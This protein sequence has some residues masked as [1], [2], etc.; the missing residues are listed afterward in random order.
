MIILGIVPYQFLPVRIGGQKAIEQ[1]YRSLGKKLPVTVVSTLHNDI[2]AARHFLLKPIFSNSGV[3][4]GNPFY[5]KKISR[6]ICE[7]ATTHLFI[8]HPY[9]GWMG[10]YLKTKH[11]I[12]L[13]VH[14]HNIE[15]IRFKSLNKW[16]WKLLWYYEKY[17]YQSADFLFFMTEED[18]RYAINNYRLLPQ[19]AFVAPYGTEIQQPPSF[20]EKQAAKQKICEVLQIGDYNTLLFFNGSF[21]YQ[22]NRDALGVLL[23]S[24]LPELNRRSFL[25][26]LIVCGRN[27]PQLYKN[28]GTEHVIFLD[29]V[30]DIFLYNLAAD[31]FVNPVTEGGG[32]KTKLVEALA[33]GANAVSAESGAA[34]INPS[35]CNGKLIITADGDYRSFASAIYEASRNRDE[36][37]SLFYQHFY[38]E[39]ITDSVIRTI[40]GSDYK[41]L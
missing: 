27:I 29:Y 21:D 22:P 15:S 39:N 3:R 11:R 26:T 1:L 8:E 23:R 40:A 20:Q 14:S 24:I 2:S 6:I 9:M 37:G 7:S 4:Y 25:F 32:I 18:R 12:P 38:I 36:T 16:W 28:E 34:G 31:V 41:T 13:V 17:V 10:I 33:A 35:F 5:L 19:K 30:D